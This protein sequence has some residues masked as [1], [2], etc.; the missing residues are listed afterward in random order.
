M[1]LEWHGLLKAVAVILL[2]IAPF[3]PTPFD[4]LMAGL[5][6]LCNILAELLK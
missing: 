2:T 6:Q 5:G 4:R 1:R 3:A